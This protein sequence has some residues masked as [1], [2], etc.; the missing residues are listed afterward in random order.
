MIASSRNLDRLEE[1]G[2]I[3]AIADHSSDRARSIVQLQALTAD[4]IR[5]KQSRGALHQDPSEEVRRRLPLDASIVNKVR[6]QTILVTGGTGCIGRALVQRLLQYGPRRVIAISRSPAPRE[7]SVHGVVRTVYAD[8]RDR[9]S[10]AAVFARYRPEVVY[11]LAA[12]RLPSLGEIEIVDT[13]STNVFGTRNIVDLSREFRASQCLVVST[14]KAVNYFPSQV[15]NQTKKL[16]EWVVLGAPVGNG[17]AY[18]VIRLTHVIDNSWLLHK[19]REGMAKG[20]IG[21]QAPDISFYAQ[22]VEEAT[23]LLLNVLSLVERGRARIFSSQELGWP[24]NLL[25]LAL[26]KIYESK[27]KAGIYFVGSQPGYEDHIF[28]GVIDWSAP[29]HRL[30]HALHSALERHLEEPRAT[31]AG[32]RVSYAPLCDARTLAHA[33]EQLQGTIEERPIESLRLRFALKHAVSQL[34]F[35]MF[36]ETSPAYLLNIA[37]W[38]ASPSVLSVT[39]TDVTHHRDT[40]IPLMQSLLPRVTPELLLRS[41]WHANEWEAF[42]NAMSEIPELRGVITE[43]RLLMGNRSLSIGAIS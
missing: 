6:D 37:R 15:Y 5:R 31:A 17:P 14:A 42:L 12:Q 35:Q 4:L 3:C 8:I 1:V 10:L 21:L 22:H 27:G 40:L 24:I 33:L 32:V 36:M 38:G 43:W 28:R 39:G 2:L 7:A 23:D 11:H 20:L 41:D 16:E 30:P 19:M 34:V 25:D 9:D 29:T 18:G 13:I 26:Y